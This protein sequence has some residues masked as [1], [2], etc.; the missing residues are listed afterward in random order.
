VP[1]IHNLP[2]TPAFRDERP[3]SPISEIALRVV[4]ERSDW[5]FE[6]VGTATLIS[7]YLA[8]TAN[9][10]LE[11]AVR[12]YGFTRKE[13][14]SIE[15]D[16]FELKLWQVLP[17]PA[18]RTWRVFAAWPCATDVVILHLGLDR[19]SLPGETIQWR[20]PRL[21]VLPPPLGQTVVAFGYRESRITVTE[22][23]GQH[24]IDLN[25]RPRTSIGKIK[26]VY[27]SGRDS[28]MLQRGLI[29]A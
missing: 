2:E 3:D 20:H 5:Q 29:P 9:H 15:I 10:V 25:D 6:V 22:S 1:T 7:A 13:T 8:I 21:R 18:Y 27:S 12:K 23:D 17:G 19:T 11:H 4:V 26:E 14:A 28:V 24:H 16:A